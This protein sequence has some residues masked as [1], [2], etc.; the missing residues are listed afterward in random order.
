MK[1]ILLVILA[2]LILLIQPIM[3]EENET[4]DINSFDINTL[5]ENNCA[6]CHTLGMPHPSTIS[7]LPAPPMNA[8]IFHVKNELKDYEKQKAFIVNYALNPQAEHSV[9]DMTKVEKFGVMPSLKGKVSKENLNRI[10]THLLVQFPTQ[11]FVETRAEAKLYKEI[12]KLRNSPFLM[13][14]SALPKV[15]LLLMKHWGK[16]KLGLTEEQKEKLLAIR[17]DV[18]KNIK[19]IKE[20]LYNLEHDI[21]EMTIYEGELELIESKVNETAKLKAKATM[22]QIKCLLES[23]EILTEKQMAVLV[24][25]WGA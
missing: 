6:S 17:S 5:I 25:L 1:R 4:N 2:L 13:N 21:I 22:I 3:A 7:S 15:T 24:P 9:C 14:Q 19:S 18:I 16:G 12:N 8:V 20:Q 11:K 10:A 23:V